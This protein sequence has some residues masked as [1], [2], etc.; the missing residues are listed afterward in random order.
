MILN[1]IGQ[2]LCI[3]YLKLSKTK[4]SEK[5]TNY[6]FTAGKTDAE[7]AEHLKYKESGLPFNPKGTLYYPKLSSAGAPN[8]WVYYPD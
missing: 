1:P 6:G 8:K 5:K 4:A 7:I 3:S 2:I